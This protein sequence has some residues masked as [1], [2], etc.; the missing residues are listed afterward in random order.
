MNLVVA[1]LLVVLGIAAMGLA[2]FL[3]L[4]WPGLILLAGAVVAAVG[5][6]AIPVDRGDR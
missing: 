1:V 2:L 6:V 3:V 5:L 4:A